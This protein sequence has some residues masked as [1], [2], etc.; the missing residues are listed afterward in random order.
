MSVE[1]LRAGMWASPPLSL[2][3]LSLDLEPLLS[4]TFLTISQGGDQTE[5]KEAEAETLKRKAALEEGPELGMR[6]IAE[7]GNSQGRQ[8]T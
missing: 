2:R 1:E 3:F 6:L 8:K 4:R 5:D 7:R